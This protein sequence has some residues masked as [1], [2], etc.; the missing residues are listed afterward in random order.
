MSTE[1][2]SSEVGGNTNPNFRSKSF[3]LTINNYS[4]DEYKFACN[5]PAKRKIVAKEVGEEKGV[6]H[7]HAVYIF[8][9][10]KRWTAMKKMFPR[11]NIQKMRGKWADQEYLL[12]GGDVFI[13][14]N[15]K[16][17]RRND[18]HEFISDSKVK[19]EEEIIVKHPGPWCK[20]QRAYNRLREMKEKKESRPFRKLEV[21]VHWGETGTGKTRTAYEEGAFMWNPSSPEWWDGYAGEEIIL[22]DEFYGQLKPAR[23]LK[24]LD[25]Y[26]CRLPVKGGFTYAKWT[27]VYITSNVRFDEWYKNIPNEVLKA[28]RRRI[29][30]VI[31]FKSL[32]KR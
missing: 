18:I 3:F 19:T 9:N 26:Q 21:I 22:I 29:T 7:I 13:E 17:G 23:L 32:L 30:K 15:S 10:V 31:E 12:K 5:L 8:K 24:L 1:V 2:L 25:G 27:K 14:D 28:L 4:P 16:Q 20:Y 6:P 11:A